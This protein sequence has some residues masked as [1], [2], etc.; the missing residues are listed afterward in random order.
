MARADPSPRCNALMQMG[1]VVLRCK[2]EDGHGGLHLADIIFNGEKCDTGW[3]DNDHG[4]Y[5][6]SRDSGASGF[7]L[8]D[9]PGEVA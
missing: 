3:S 6:R 1:D 5:Y 8:S 7:V 4:A 2:R 9:S